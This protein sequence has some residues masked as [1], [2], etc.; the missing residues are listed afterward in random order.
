MQ[1][2]LPK[3]QQIPATAVSVSDYESLARERVSAVAWAFLSGGAADEW[4]L[5]ENIAAFQRVTLRPRVL[6]DL[7]GGNT[8]V[9]LFGQRFAAPILLAPI[10]YHRMFHPDGELGTVMAAGAMQTGMVVSTQATTLIEDVAR[11]AEGSKT[12]LWF[13]LYVQAD[14]DFTAALV[15]RA[16]A[17]GYG[18]LVVTVDAPVTGIRNREQRAGFALP[19]GLDAPNVRD[20]RAPT[21]QT[22]DNSQL[23]FGG[24]LLAAAMTWRDVAWLRSLTRLPLIAKGIMTGEDAQRAVA[25]GFDG[26][27]VSNHGG[28]TLDTQPAT[29]DVLAEIVAAAAS[30]VPVLCDGGIRRGSD[31]FKALALG[32]K[33]VMIGRPYVYGLAAAGA[34]GVAH[35][36]R[37]L[38][39]ELEVTM[40]LCGCKDL[41]AIDEARIR[42]AL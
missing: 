25:E 19:P 5:R 2:P 33:A 38:R 4:T 36:I 34:L 24:P 17:A 8:A 39:A 13:Q 35:I 20:M 32:A 3:L 22:G 9:E 37:I 15:R 16:E 28:R 31:V 40:A 6:M 14:R 12:P 11:Q 42:R 7:S 23:L 41:S 27:V 29:I 10:A 26:I 18:A 30:R 1:Q 21:V